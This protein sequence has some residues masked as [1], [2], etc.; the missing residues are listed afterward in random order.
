MLG[1]Q[2]L[3]G[4]CNPEEQELMEKCSRPLCALQ[5]LRG[6]QMVKPTVVTCLVMP[7]D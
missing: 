6:P 4:P 3:S 5:T 2:S 1:V 7:L